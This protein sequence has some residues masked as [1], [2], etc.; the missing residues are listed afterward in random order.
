[1]TE[2][3][4]QKSIAGETA[5]VAA[6]ALAPAIALGISRFAYALILPDMRDDL[7]WS[8]ALAGWLNASNAVGYLLGAMVASRLIAAVGAF[9]ATWWGSVACALGVLACAL[10]DGVPALNAARLV[11][12][13]GGAFAFV[14]GGV[15]AAGI[16]ARH[17]ERGTFLLGLF[18]AG[19]G[20]GIVLSG[21]A[22]P[23]MLGGAGGGSWR[24]AWVLLAVLCLPMI[25]LLARA[26][27]SGGGQ[28]ALAGGRARI[29]PMAPM[30]AGYFCFG[31]GYI[32]YM[33]FMFAYVRGLGAGLGF[34][35]V[36]WLSIGVGVMGAPWAWA[37]LQSRLRHG[38]GFAVA[39]AVVA[40]AAIL[41]LVTTAPVALV[42]SGLCFGG[43]F[44]TVVSSTTQFVRRNLAPGAITAG[45]GAFTTAFGLGQTLGPVV[46]GAV[47]DAL[48]AVSAGLWG[49]ALTLFGAVVLGLL[50]R[51][52]KE[53]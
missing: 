6:L 12:G 19:P 20:L 24:G 4:G 39:N 18:Y 45:I 3:A 50:Q 23:V 31:A 37:A 43:S 13:V 21:L 29:M 46:S 41:P 34:Q 14:G 7:G 51:D 26:R 2:G 53:A 16:A 28:A 5:M 17:P 11:S 25:L 44:L 38:H 8:Y 15:L 22:V 48:G 42:V 36:F 40:A 49:S 9:A 10:F 32:A 1:M 27:R 47:T 30:L 33:T 52:L 35:V